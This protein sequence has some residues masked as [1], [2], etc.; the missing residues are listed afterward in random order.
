MA[1]LL[2]EHPVVRTSDPKL[3]VATLQ[4][5][6]PRV[7]IRLAVADGQPLRMLMNAAEVGTLTASYIH[8]GPPVH[9]VAGETDSYYLNIA[10]RGRA[11][12]RAEHLDVWSDHRQAA[13][14]SPGLRGEIAWDDG[15]AQLCVMVSRASV[16]RQLELYLGRSL[17]ESPRFEPVMDLTTKR[18]ASWLRALRLVHQQMESDESGLAGHPL[19]V[20]QIENL[21]VAGLLVVQ[22][23]SY[24]AALQQPARPG[25]PRAVRAAI[26][27]L[28]DQ[29][30][31]GWSV[32]EL[33]HELHISVRALQQGFREAL[34]TPPMRYL[35]DVRLSRVHAE[36]LAAAAG[37]VT[38][39][40]VAGRWGFIHHGHFAAAYRA[41]YG[42]SPTRTLQGHS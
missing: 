16:H 29:P 30:E 2:A 36:L 34:G 42:E 27:L 12:W 20:R 18:A 4:R 41:R 1:E 5:V 7:P 22:P 26:E 14:L 39:T 31:R 10:L 37:E 8:F 15:C 40:Q 24:T 3:A 19:V 33:A 21:V 32:G 38:V 13:V 23:H 6:L 17:S 25:P 28:E 11:R 35:R 9:M